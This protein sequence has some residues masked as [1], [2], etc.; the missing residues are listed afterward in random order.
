MHV[1]SP[2]HASIYFA[3]NITPDYQADH[4]VA[5]CWVTWPDQ[6]NVGCKHEKVLH[7]GDTYK[8]PPQHLGEE[9][10]LEIADKNVRS[11]LCMRGHG[12]VYAGTG[13]K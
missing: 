11:M 1:L 4:P 8:N 9:S 10:F 7:E 2:D 5:E 12:A 13:V 3:F 6:L